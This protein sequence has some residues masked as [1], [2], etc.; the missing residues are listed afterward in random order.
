MEQY[1]Q[2]IN[3]KVSGAIEIV[4]KYREYNPDAQHLSVVFDIDGTLL[5]DDKPIKPVVHLYNLCKQLGYTVFIVTARDSI[6]IAETINQLHNLGINGFHSVYFRIPSVWNI[7]KFKAA[8]RKSV[9]D[10]GYYTVL[11][12]GDSSWDLIQEGENEPGHGI[13]LPQ[14]IF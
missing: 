3:K 10:K 12:I 1:V 5:N 11:T 14:L 13:L 8:C 9:I 2:E 6:G 4:E 7:V